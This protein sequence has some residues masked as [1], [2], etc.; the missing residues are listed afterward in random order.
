CGVSEILLVDPET[1]EFEF[2]VLRGGKYLAVLPDDRHA[3]RSAVLGVTFARV[4]GP[5]LRVGTTEI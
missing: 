2:H 1:R 3:V 4:D 5:R